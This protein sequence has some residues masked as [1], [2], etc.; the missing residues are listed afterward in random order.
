MREVSLLPSSLRLDFLLSACGGFSG[1][2]SDSNGRSAPSPL[3]GLVLFGGGA[4]GGGVHNRHAASV[5]QA[6]RTSSRTWRA[7]HACTRRHMFPFWTYVGRSH[8]LLSRAVRQRTCSYR[9]N[10]QTS[11]ESHTLT[12]RKMCIIFF[13]PF[14]SFLFLACLRIEC[15][16]FV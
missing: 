12:F 8:D 10:N 5:A 6:Q 4:M 3:F 7:F 15:P 16:G 11:T 1:C 14:L 9:E 2:S 13:F